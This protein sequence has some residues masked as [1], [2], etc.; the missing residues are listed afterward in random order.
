MTA[1]VRPRLVVMDMIGT[2]VA[3]G[4][5]VPE[6]FRAAFREAGVMLSEAAVREVRGRSK[7]EAI[8]S[9]VAIH[10]PDVADPDTTAAE[11]HD[12]FRAMLQAFHETDATEVPG[13]GATIEELGRLGMPVVLTTGLDRD[14][15]ERLL[16]GLAW[17]SANLLGL[18]T[19]DD[20]ARGRPAPDLIHAAMELADESEGAAV[21][22][23]GDTVSDLEAAAAAGVGW[24]IGVL[25]GAHARERLETAQH[26]AILESVTAL[27]LWLREAGFGR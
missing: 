11:I 2:T 1:P 17:P 15:A 10:L 25:T 20:V 5:E 9:L 21:L 23:V 18:I 27:P 4:R 22:A 19:G 26:T 16:R 8:A 6:A 7:T 14:T 3:S 24:S 12:R 13:A